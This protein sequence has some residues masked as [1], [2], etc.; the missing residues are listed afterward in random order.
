MAMEDSSVAS[1]T[2]EETDCSDRQ[3]PRLALVEWAVFLRMLLSG[4]PPTASA[5]EDGSS[6]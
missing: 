4:A 5:E 2:K 1:E 3:R 6:S